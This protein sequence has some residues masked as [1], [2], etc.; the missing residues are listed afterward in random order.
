[1]VQPR[2]SS[3]AGRYE[4]NFAGTGERKFQVELMDVTCRYPF[5]I[6]SSAPLT[7]RMTSVKRAN[8]LESET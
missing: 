5:K 6:P 3:R 4:R 2:M 8:K 7:M 1:V